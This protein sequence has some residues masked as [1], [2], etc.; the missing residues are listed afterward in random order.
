MEALEALPVWSLIPS[1]QLDD[2]SLIPVIVEQVPFSEL[3]HLYS[4]HFEHEDIPSVVSQSQNLSLLEG[5]SMEGGILLSDDTSPS[6]M[7]TEK[8]LLDAE[9]PNNILDEN[10]MRFQVNS[11]NAGQNRMQ[12]TAPKAKRARRVPK[13]KAPCYLP[14]VVEAIFP[15]QRKSKDGRVTGIF[16]WEF[17]LALLRNKNTS[18]RYIK[19][20]HRESG[21]FK[22]VDSRA[23]SKMWGKQKNKPNMNYETMGR[24]MRYYYRKG[25]LSKVT[26]QRLSYRFNNM[27]R[28]TVVINDEDRPPVIETVIIEDSDPII[29]LEEEVEQR[30]LRR[31]RNRQARAGVRVQK[32]PGCCCCPPSSWPPS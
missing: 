7:A 22:L 26:G 15:I 3:L 29:T 32:T 18:P 20:V 5:Q 25:I 8:V 28:E 30:R 19:W 1:I 6:I 21:V 2:P 27:P 9:A 10:R 23:V 4:T 31:R 13:R 24:A 11:G 12:G 16:L 14:P 17:L